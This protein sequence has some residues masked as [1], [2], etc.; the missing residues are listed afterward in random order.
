[1][2]GLLC[3]EDNACKSMDLRSFYCRSTAELTNGTDS[4]S[5]VHSPVFSIRAKWNVVVHN[6]GAEFRVI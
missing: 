3:A 5:Q 2:F 6:D 1:M 4:T